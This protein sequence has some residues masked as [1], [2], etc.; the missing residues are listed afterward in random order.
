MHDTTTLYTTEVAFVAN[1]VAD[2]SV[3]TTPSNGSSRQ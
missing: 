2:F 1:N 3:G